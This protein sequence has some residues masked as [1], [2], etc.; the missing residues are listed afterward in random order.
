[1]KPPP[2]DY[3]DPQ[4]L[5]DALALAASLENAKLLAGGQ[6]L[7]PM[8]NMRFAQ[9]DHI[10]DL[11]RVPELTGIRHT[12]RG[13][14]IGAMTRQY[15]IEFS[16]LVAARCPL[17]SEAIKLVGHRQTRNR[18]TIGGSLCHLDPAAEL[19]CVAAAMDAIVEVA[20]RERAREIGFADFA[21]GYM[22]TALEPDEIA[23]KIV[24]PLWPS[25]SGY[26]FME[27]SRRHG[28][29]AVASAAVLLDLDEKGR[30]ARAAVALGGVDVAPIRM[31][32]IER[33][34]VGSP[35]TEA[36]IGELSDA[37]RALDVLE[38]AFFSASYRQTL[39]AVMCKRAL[40]TA[41]RRSQ[42]VH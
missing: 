26:A 38:D 29:F 20:N 24:T 9:P 18:G 11:N 39:A 13:L 21:L 40:T 31:R 28:D 25:T 30:V 10:I 4:T 41:L 23:T 35:L 15:E 37:C 8:L 7:V 6:S 22:T 1:M 33:E 19:V 34:L 5:G 32:E 27:F 36:K 12:E 3:H 42:A 14:E 16:P 17:M 2:F